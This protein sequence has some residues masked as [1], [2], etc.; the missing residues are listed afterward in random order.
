MLRVG[1]L[2]GFPL[3]FYYSIFNRPLQPFFLVFLVFWYVPPCLLNLYTASSFL[4]LFFASAMLSITSGKL[5]F[6][7]NPSYFAS[8]NFINLFE[9][10]LLRLEY[11]LIV[12][13]WKLWYNP[14]KE[15]QRAKAAYPP[16]LEGLTL[17]SFRK[18][19]LPMI[20]YQD[21]FLFCTFIV[22]LI[23]LLYQIF[24]GKK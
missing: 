10:T 15:S 20:T 12:E 8:R 1:R 4:T 23:S 14:I 5:L 24:K 22:S 18:E 6:T 3:L 17:Q 19:G 2:S 16:P 11:I 9:S 7:S 13:F 21:F